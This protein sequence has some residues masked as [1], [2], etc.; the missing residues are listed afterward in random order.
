MKIKKGGR[1]R[2]FVAGGGRIRLRRPV[3][4]PGSVDEKISLWV[5]LGR[6]VSF[7]PIMTRNKGHFRVVFVVSV[8]TAI[9]S[10]LDPIV[11]DQRDVRRDGFVRA[12]QMDSICV[13]KR[14]SRRISASSRMRVVICGSGIG[15]AVPVSLLVVPFVMAWRSESGVETRMSDLTM[16]LLPCAGVSDAESST[17]LF[18]VSAMFSFNLIPFLKAVMRTPVLADN[19][20][21]S[22]TI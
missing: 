17:S 16:V 21:P 14:G 18:S 8:E 19:F 20:R 1:R 9:S 7:S 4:L 12:D 11:A 2:G 3:N 6:D 13:R 22:F 15:A 5:M 10:M